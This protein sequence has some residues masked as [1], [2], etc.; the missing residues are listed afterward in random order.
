MVWVWGW[1][2]YH[3]CLMLNRVR[4]VLKTL[5]VK[6]E[7]EVWQLRE[8]EKIALVNLV[9]DGKYLLLLSSHQKAP[10]RWLLFKD[11]GLSSTFGR[12]PF[13]IDYVLTEVAEDMA[14]FHAQW[15]R[16]NPLP[17]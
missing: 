14:Y 11:Q 4:L 6:K 13:Q 5:A 17:Y 2:I 10:L 15:S 16:S 1:V 9:K 8:R 12:Q 7:K 3:V